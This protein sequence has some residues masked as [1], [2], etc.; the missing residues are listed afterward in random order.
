MNDMNY[1][2]GV[3]GMVCGIMALRSWYQVKKTGDYKKSL[4]YQNNSPVVKRC[5]DVEAYN[6]ETLPKLL[7][8]GILAEFYGATEL[9]NSW[10]T[11][12]PEILVI[13][14]VVLFASLIWA[15]VTTR[16][17]NEKYF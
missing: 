13:S 12:I 14:M 15:T 7:I 17:L 9:Y 2:F 3:V 8:V 4:F 10:V 6:R 5:K 1:I 11:P 16:K